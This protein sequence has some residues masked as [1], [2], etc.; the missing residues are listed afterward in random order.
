MFFAVQFVLVLT[1]QAT[2]RNRYKV[3]ESALKIK[4]E[5]SNL[6]QESKLL[7]IAEE[8][9][10]KHLLRVRFSFETKNKYCFLLK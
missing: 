9:K 7:K 1:L 4:L 3:L 2:L 5:M 6:E 10:G 8:F